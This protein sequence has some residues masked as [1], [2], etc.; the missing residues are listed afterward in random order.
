MF[1]NLGLKYDGLVS[2]IQSKW[3]KENTNVANAILQIIHY[4]YILKESNP[5]VLLMGQQLAKES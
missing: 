1:Y 3:Q 2:S 4:E 5:K